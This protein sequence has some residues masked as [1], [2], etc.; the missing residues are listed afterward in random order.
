LAAQHR[1]E[2]L[3]EALHDKVQQEMVGAWPV[4]PKDPAPQ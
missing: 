2:A 4:W 1:Q 3:L